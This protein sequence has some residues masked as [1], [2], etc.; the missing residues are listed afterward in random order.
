MEEGQDEL[1]ILK[2]G[3]EK[4]ISLGGVAETGRFIDQYA[5]ELGYS[6]EGELIADI[7]GKKVLDLGSGTGTFAKDVADR[8]I[9]CEVVSVNPRLSK[10][11][12]RIIEKRSTNIDFPHSRETVQKIH[13]KTALAAFAH[14]LPFPDETFD[15]LFDN[16]AV[17]R[18][19][20][21]PET[22]VFKEAVK[23]MY[24]VLKRGGQIRIGDRAGYG[25]AEK[26]SRQQIPS[27]REHVLKDLGLNYSINWVTWEDG[28]KHS[29][30]VVITKSKENVTTK[31]K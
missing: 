11:S 29:Y 21:K 4:K 8:G 5:D 3:V 19:S 17:S 7:T 30:G 13:N 23:E 27:F 12:F 25:W 20:R 2:R 31:Q 22:L 15:L 14:N 6:D 1:A 18:S 9:N 28:S 10:Q 24:R 16:Q 26:G